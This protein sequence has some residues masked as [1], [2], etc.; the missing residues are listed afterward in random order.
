MTA[1]KIDCP[2]SERS[3]RITKGTINAAELKNIDTNNTRG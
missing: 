2:K 1:E 3:K